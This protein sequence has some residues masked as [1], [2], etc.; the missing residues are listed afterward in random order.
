MLVGD[1]AYWLQINRYVGLAWAIQS[2]AGPKEDVPGGGN[3]KNPRLEDTILKSQRERWFDLTFDEL[4]VAF[5]SEP[6]PP[7]IEGAV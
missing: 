1:A 2:I 4:D 7:D 5:D 3:P 6:F